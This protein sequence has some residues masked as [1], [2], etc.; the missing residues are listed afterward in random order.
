MYDAENVEFK[1]FRLRRH[2]K[3]TIKELSQFDN[4]KPVEFE[5]EFDHSDA[6]NRPISSCINL[7]WSLLTKAFINLD[8]FF[9]QN[10]LPKLVIRELK[11]TNAAAVTFKF[12]FN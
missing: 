8:P 10:L 6:A 11:Q 7:T 9:R 3:R 1:F 2:L 5:S 12:P 4:K